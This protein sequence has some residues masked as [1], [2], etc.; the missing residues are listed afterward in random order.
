MLHSMPPIG[1]ENEAD[2]SKEVLTQ[3]EKLRSMKESFSAD[4]QETLE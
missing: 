1:Q 3:K 4:K 2:N